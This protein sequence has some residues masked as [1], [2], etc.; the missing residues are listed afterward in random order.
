MMFFHEVEAQGL[1]VGHVQVVAIC[2]VSVILPAVSEHD[3]LV[4]LDTSPEA[5]QDLC[6]E[7]VS[8]V[9]FIK[10]FL[11]EGA[12]I[13]GRS[14]RRQTQVPLRLLLPF[15]RRFRVYHQ[16]VLAASDF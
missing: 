16:R 10:Q 6:W 2:E 9:N 5:V 14:V 1:V 12:P 11:Q 13:S 7:R 4:V 15:F 8:M 3:I